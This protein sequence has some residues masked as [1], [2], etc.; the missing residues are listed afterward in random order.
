MLAVSEVQIVLYTHSH[1]NG[2]GTHITTFAFCRS[3]YVHIPGQ[4]WVSSLCSDSRRA[5]GS[6]WKPKT[7][8]YTNWANR[9]S[10]VKSTV[11]DL[12]VLGDRGRAA[13]FFIRTSISIRFP[14]FLCLF[15]FLLLISRVSVASLSRSKSGTEMI[16]PE[17]DLC[18][19]SWHSKAC[20]C[21]S[22][23]HRMR[24]LKVE[25]E[26]ESSNRH[27]GEIGLCRRQAR[28]D[29]S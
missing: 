19:G 4:Q 23:L 14:P 22:S 17:Q 5:T 28:V 10:F 27:N 7:C 8:R 3:C 16:Q 1:S 13:S 26:H 9:I 18:L 11:E 24:R 6:H 15:V 12:S 25:N 21:K 29:S 20:G 2:D